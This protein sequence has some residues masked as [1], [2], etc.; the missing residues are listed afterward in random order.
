MKRKIV[1]HGCSSLTITLPYSWVNKFNL[2]K[3]DEIDVSEN[4]SSLIISTETEQSTNKK[5]VD[6]T[7]FGYFTKNNLAHLYQLGYDE[8]EIRYDDENTLKELKE[9]VNECIGFEII[10][11]KPNKIFIKSIAQ[12]LDSEFDILLRK[13]FLITHEMAVNVLEAIKSQ[14]YHK[15]KE[16]RHQEFMNNKFTMVCVRILSKRGYKEQKKI[17][18]VHNIIK[19]LERIADEYKYICDLMYDYDKKVNKQV[20]EFFEK[21]NQYYYTFYQMFYKFDPKLKEAIYKG[22]K[23]LKKEGEMLITSN[24]GNESMLAHYLFTLIDKVNDASG[25]YFAL[26]L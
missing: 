5:E 22:R 20:I 25:A 8:I 7:Q 16:I 9:K 1:Q 15:L 14:Q 3:G 21:I 13:C 18:H 11:Q 23:E 10:D 2:K 26:I 12:T 19:Q 24:K 6:T 4:G 17:M